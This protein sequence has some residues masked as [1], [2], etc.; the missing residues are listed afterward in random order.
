MNINDVVLES[1]FF[2]NNGEIDL[3]TGTMAPDRFNQ[4]VNRDIA[5]A[6]RNHSTLGMV[7]IKTNLHKFIGENGSL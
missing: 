6:N 1:I 7:S 3:L 4:L 5:I 2:V